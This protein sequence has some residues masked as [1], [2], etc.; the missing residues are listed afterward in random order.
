MTTLAGPAALR[1]GAGPV[2]PVLPRVSGPDDLRRL[3][4]AELD[5]LAAEVRAFLVDTVTG[6]GG[7]LGPNLGVVEL[8]FALHRVF[9]SPRD[10]LVW[11]TGHQSYVHKIVTG[12]G[13][14]LGTLRQSGGLSGYPSRAESEHD[15]VE[16]SHA[17]TALSYADGLAKAFAVRGERERAVVAVVGDGALTGGMCWEALNNIGAA[18]QRPVVVVLNDNGRSYAPTVGA[19]AGQLAAVRTG[20]A[21]THENPAAAVFERLGLRYLG[22]VDGH[23]VAQVEDALRLA[24][25]L[26]RPVLVHCV[27]EK[28][29][30]HRPALAHQ[31][32]RMHS[33]SPSPAGGPSSGPSAD[34]SGASSG[35]LSGAS[36][37]GQSGG[38]SGGPAWTDVFGEEL[39]RIGGRRPDVVAVTAA[40]AHPAGLTAF[41][42]RCPDRFYDVGI[43]EQHAVTSAAG[44][45]MAGLHPVVAIYATFLNRAFDQVLLDVGLHR[46]PVT[47]VLDRAGVTGND[48]PSHHGMWDLSL[49]GTVPGMRI[50]APRDAARLRELLGEA[51]ADGR[52]PT[53]VRFPKGTAPDDL[54]AVGRVGSVEVLRRGASPQV[55]LLAAGA[56]AGPACAAAGELAAAGVAVTVLDPR[57]VLPVDAALVR[58]AARYRLVVTVE[59]HGLCGGF[60]DALVRALRAARVH[61]EVQTL[62]LAQQYLRHGERRDL[63]REQGLDAPGIAAAIRGADLTP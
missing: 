14:E 26:R 23:D 61:V 40:M 48:G 21:G 32:D 51:V 34:P 36:S 58:E 37:G 63:L 43:A 18:P 10:V 50:A 54:P 24:R 30:G 5:A 44:M 42:A 17:S 8:T 35:A 13:G 62:G 22:P 11:D 6:T 25:S 20:T 47:F 9:D 7:H 46:L 53:A 3:G 39:A 15:L 57:W 33:I 19:L 38:P 28:G 31:A 60:G 49:L 2:L 27:T 52:G 59:D 29:R 4:P 1:D 12:R 56:M 55:L 41:A 16:N 45:A